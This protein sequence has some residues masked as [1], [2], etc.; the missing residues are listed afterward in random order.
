MRSR[1]VCAALAALCV[2]GPAS[3]QPKDAGPAVELRLRSVNDLLDRAEYVAGLAGQEAAVGQA[4]DFL[5]SLAVEGKGI[6]GIDPKRPIGAYARLETDI[7]TSPFVFMLP[8]ADEKAFLDA[9]QTHL[10]VTTEKGENGTLKA[11]VPLINQVHLRFAN[12]YLYIAPNAGDLDPG[13]L[14]SPKA[15]FGTDDGSFASLA[16]HIDRIPADLRK[17]AFG[18]FEL[19]LNE[20]RK[21]NAD[22]ESAAEKKLKGVI[23][24]GLLGGGKGL[25]EDGTALTLKLFADPKS[26]E[27]S[28]EAALTARPGT[29]TAKNVAA[30]G[31]KV[32]LPAGIV[33]AA[34]APAARFG[35]TASVTPGV[36]KEYAAAIR[37]LLEQAL[38]DA[39]ADG[40]DVFEAL[41]AAVSPTLEAGNLDVAG[42]LLS[43]NAKGHHVA[44][45]AGAVR[46]GKGIET[47]VKK[48][49][50]Q[51]GQF[52]E[53]EVAFKFD[54]ET[55]GDFAL[56][57]VELK[58]AP[59]KFEKVFGTGTIWLA[60][61]AE[62]LAFSI[63][64]EG[65]VLRKAL[66]AKAAP[67]PVLQLDIAASQLLKVAQPDLKPDELKAL[68]RDAFGDGPTAGKDTIRVTVT[69]GTALTAKATVKGKA[70]RM[71]AALGLLK[72][73]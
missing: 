25:L 73:N 65:D 16:V 50:E 60:T 1:W 3:A 41:V 68:L 48:T 10:Q 27:V 19:G 14:V 49:V 40:K 72:G 66:K 15:Y 30:L 58:N 70:L 22:R 17:F 71:F 35:A 32:S 51:Y 54:V 46:E 38:K 23:F 20:E 37:A 36:Q 24:D 69:G 18:Q 2:C 52:I 13:K 56:H 55:V 33:A 7:K 28:L 63:E 34:G 26:D 53:N 59:E 64:P 44:I 6:Q 9:L 29:P 47:F 62:H 11:A 5:K 4:R 42:A 39:P 12:G 57:K 31:E 45:G 61:S 21:K 67:A 8:I 43:A